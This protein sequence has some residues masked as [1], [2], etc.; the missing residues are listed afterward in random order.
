VKESFTLIDSVNH[1]SSLWEIAGSQRTARPVL[2]TSGS[3]PNECC[4]VWTSSGNFFVFQATTDGRADLWML[5]GAATADP[6]RVTNGPLFYEA[7][8]A[9]L[10]KGEGH[11][12]PAGGP[13]RRRETLL[14][15]LKFATLAAGQEYPGVGHT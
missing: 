10:I 1:A 15:P 6:V 4:G 13:G 12:E 7:P 8:A 2:K 9:G 14:L 5:K 3:S 11:L